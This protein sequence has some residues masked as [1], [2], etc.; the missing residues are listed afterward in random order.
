MRV[1]SAQDNKQ[2]IP[3][4]SEVTHS[5]PVQYIS[6]EIPI[7]P[8]PGLLLRR[9]FHKPFVSYPFIALIFSRAAEARDS[10]LLPLRAW[11]S[12]GFA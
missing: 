9:V 5:P 10:R 6:F 11:P 8:G 3:Q 7:S 4:I 12:F 1:A 2:I